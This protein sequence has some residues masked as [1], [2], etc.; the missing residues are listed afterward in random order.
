MPPLVSVRVVTYNHEKYVAQCLEGILMQHTDFLFEVIVGEDC[1]TDGTLE[2]V[3]AYEKKCPDR[4][5][6][7]TSE[8][9][10]GG[11]QNSLRI[12]Q[13]CRGKYHAFCEGDDYWIDP[14]KLQKQ[15]NFMESHPEYS[16]CF[17]DAFVVRYD[18]SAIPGYVC[19]PALPECLT[20]TD[21]LRFKFTIPTASVLARGNILV[22]LPKWQKDIRY[23]D[24][25]LRLWCAHH[26]HLEYLGEAMSVYR[27]HPG[28]MIISNRSLEVHYSSVTDVYRRFDEETAYQYTDLI[29]KVYK[30]I[31]KEYRFERMK[32]RLGWFS[33]LLRPDKAIERL[34][35]YANLFIRYRKLHSW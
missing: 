27:I 17:H 9:N 20:I 2:I 11:T 13:A 10:I 19:P 3:R 29:G 5:R 15:V 4:V 1:S 7:I 18:K 22:S 35:K 30:R 24:L 12:Q 28:G 32:K 26:G 14:L 8:K 31:N 33:F 6:V 21:L 34:R 25:L 16:M 23:G